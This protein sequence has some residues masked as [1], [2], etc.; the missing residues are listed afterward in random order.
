VPMVMVNCASCPLL[1]MTVS[2]K[3]RMRRRKPDAY[4]GDYF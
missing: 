3:V 1:L 4:R 2:Q